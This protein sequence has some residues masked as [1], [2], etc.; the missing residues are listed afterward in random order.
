MYSRDAVVPRTRWH[1]FDVLVSRMNG[2]SLGSAM[3]VLYL[4]VSEQQYCR[5]LKKENIHDYI[6]SDYSANVNIDWIFEQE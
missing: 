3:A 6:L 4:S 5:V 2:V 1:V